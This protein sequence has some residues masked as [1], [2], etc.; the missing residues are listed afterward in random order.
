MTLLLS[1]PTATH[2]L[3]PPGRIA[4]YDR[5]YYK[6]DRYAVFNENADGHRWQGFFTKS[7]AE[8][9]AD[10]SYRMERQEAKMTLAG[11]KWSPVKKEMV[12]I[13]VDS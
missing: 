12:T 13:T 3:I 8:A 5:S 6:E 11:A 2:D 9:L 1:H 10:F 7:L 4:L